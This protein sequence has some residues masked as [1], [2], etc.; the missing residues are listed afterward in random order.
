MGM[1]LLFAPAVASH[2]LRKG[3]EGM[4]GRR[5]QLGAGVLRPCGG[6][7]IPGHSALGRWGALQ[8]R[9]R[10]EMRAPLRTHLPPLVSHLLWMAASF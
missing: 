1:Q 9:S 7:E 5:P 4:P 2:H 3:L 6:K 8:A 10:I